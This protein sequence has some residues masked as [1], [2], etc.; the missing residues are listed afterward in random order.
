MERLIKDKQM[1]K[2]GDM[3]QRTQQSQRSERLEH[4]SDR[5]VQAAAP[6]TSPPAEVYPSHGHVVSVGDELCG[7]P[8]G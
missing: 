7:V 8:C 2:Q 3:S 1:N 4:S 5:R 6:S